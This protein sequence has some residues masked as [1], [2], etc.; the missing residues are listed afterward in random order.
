MTALNMKEVLAR[1]YK[2]VLIASAALSAAVV[3]LGIGWVQSMFIVD[4]P[5][6]RAWKVLLSGTIA[7]VLWPIIYLTVIRPA[8][9]IQSTCVVTICALIFGLV[10]AAV[11][12]IVGQWK[13]L[14]VSLSCLGM[15]LASI[16]YFGRLETA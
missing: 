3:G 16:S 15:L 11:T 10:G 9:N 14:P 1:L 8:L 2:C 7:A 5:D 12:R 4:D 6:I 13:Y